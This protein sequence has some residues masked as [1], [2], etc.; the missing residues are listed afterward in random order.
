[1][2]TPTAVYD[3]RTVYNHTFIKGDPGCGKS[4]A[5]YAWARYASRKHSILYLRLHFTLDRSQELFQ[6]GSHSVALLENGQMRFFKSLLNEVELLDWMREDEGLGFQFDVLVIDGVSAGKRG[7]YTARL[8][9]SCLENRFR[10]IFVCSQQVRNIYSQDNEFVHF[11]S[12]FLMDAWDEHKLQ[13]VAMMDTFWNCQTFVLQ[14]EF[15]DAEDR[16]SVI[17]QKMDV[18]GSSARYLFEIPSENVEKDLNSYAGSLADFKFLLNSDTSSNA[19]HLHNHLVRTVRSPNKRDLPLCVPLS[20]YVLELCV[21]GLSNQWEFAVLFLRNA[22]L[23]M[24][25][26]VHG[27]AFENY[28]P[29]L[30]SATQSGISKCFPDGVIEFTRKSLSRIQGNRV[31]SV[32][33]TERKEQRHVNQ[34]FYYKESTKSR[35]DCSEF[36]DSS[37]KH[38]G[39]SVDDWKPFT[40]IF[41]RKWNQGCFDIALVCSVDPLDKPLDKTKRRLKIGLEFFQVTVSHS[42]ELKLYLLHSIIHALTSLGHELN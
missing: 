28:L 24:N 12:V 18:C 11:T 10:I 5:V 8:H 23:M 22:K 17:R 40:W 2:E 38:V 9:L 33:D 34:V 4:T 32:L 30:I 7:L 25:P 3:K 31:I 21:S 16:A 6:S 20:K 29:T 1:L 26:S 36:T 35:A 39:Q 27:W 42:H 19:P 37:G 13:E 14:Q 15:K 41:P